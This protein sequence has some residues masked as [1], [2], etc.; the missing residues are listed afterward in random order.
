MKTLISLIIYSP[1]LSGPLDLKGV[2]HLASRDSA[3]NKFTIKRGRKINVPLEL[4]A[5]NGYEPK[6]AMI[7]NITEHFP[8]MLTYDWAPTEES[9]FPTAEA[10]G[11]EALPPKIGRC[12]SQRKARAGLSTKEKGKLRN[13]GREEA[14]TMGSVHQR[15]PLQLGSQ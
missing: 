11:G 6:Q 4:T 14:V 13:L 1:V 15:A 5:K 8:T 12:Q 2:K 3:F 10:V 9:A 7:P